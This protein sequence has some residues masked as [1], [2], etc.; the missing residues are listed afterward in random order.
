MFRCP[1]STQPSR[2]AMLKRRSVSCPTIRTSLGL[3]EA[4]LDPLHLLALGVP[5][6]ED[7]PEEEVLELLHAHAGVLGQGGTWGSGT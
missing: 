1:S 2:P 4:V 7:G 5:V 6:E 3:V